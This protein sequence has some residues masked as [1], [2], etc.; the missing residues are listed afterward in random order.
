MMNGSRI[1]LFTF[2][3]LIF[4]VIFRRCLLCSLSFNKVSRQVP[5]TEATD[6]ALVKLTLFLT[7]S[8][9]SFLFFLYFFPPHNSHW[10][11]EI[12]A[13]SNSTKNN[14]Q[15]ARPNMCAVHFFCKTARQHCRLYT[16]RG[17]IRQSKANNFGNLI[18]NLY[19]SVTHIPFFPPP[20]PAILTLD[21]LLRHRGPFSLLFYFTRKH[22][23]FVAAYVFLS[24]LSYTRVRY[25]KPSTVF[26]SLT[27][28]LVYY[29]P[30]LL[31]WTRTQPCWS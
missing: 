9:S 17:A 26:S 4:L 5:S 7:L 18:R 22:L 10:L 30:F 19:S 27:I 6:C 2:G 25:S 13:H 12:V 15:S 29:Y 11:S 28:Q 23:I 20:S 1:L 16:T 14:W 3:G 24:V 31:L 8:V 21:K